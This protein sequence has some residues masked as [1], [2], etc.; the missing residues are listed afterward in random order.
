MKNENLFT[1]SQFV[2]SFLERCG[3]LVENKGY[4]LWEA[5]LPDELES[6]FGQDLLV[7]AFDYE[8]AEENPGSI[9]VT[10]GSTFLDTIVRLAGDYGRYT[11]HYLPDGNATLT[12]NIENRV[13]QAVNFKHCKPPIVILHWL[14]ENVYYGFNFK[15]IYST[16]EKTEQ[17]ITIVINGW[18]GLPVPD[19]DLRMENIITLDQPTYQITEA[20]LQSVSELYKSA[21]KE[22]ENVAAKSSASVKNLANKLLKKELDR[23]NQYYQALID[24]KT[25]KIEASTDSLKSEKLTKQ[26]DAIKNEYDRRKEDT[27]SRYQVEIEIYLDHLT[28]Y[29]IPCELIKLEMK[30]KKTV[31]RQT[32]IYNR[33]IGQIESPAC[34]QCGQPTQILQPDKS[35]KLY[36][37]SCIAKINDGNS[38]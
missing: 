24:E 38:A 35:A 29:H 11:V 20:P 21:C 33:L 30:H 19:F 5:L 16:Y 4:A 34:K 31:I 18:S 22:I 27:S 32:L 28:A 36:C 10:A 25:I 15:V 2:V 12:K 37:P 6:V 9:F 13:S 1:V 17:I 3:S 8:I 26:L 23:I 7:L 14:T